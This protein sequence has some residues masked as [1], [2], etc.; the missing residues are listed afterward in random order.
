[1][2]VKCIPL[3]PLFYIEKLGFAGVYLIFLFLIE[4]HTLWI[5]VKTTVLTCTHNVCFKGKYLK[6]LIV[7]MKFSLSS[8]EKISIYYM[9]VFS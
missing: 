2:S 8:S 4:K 3:K 5:L 9:G 6:N 1:M 7:P